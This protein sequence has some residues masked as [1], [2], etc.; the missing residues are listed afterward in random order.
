MY[1]GS[2]IIV[3]AFLRYEERSTIAADGFNEAIQNAI[4]AICTSPNRFRNTYKNFREISL[5]KYPYN[6][7]YYVN[8]GNELVVI[9]SI[10][11]H[12]RNPEG[13]YLKPKK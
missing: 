4:I 1:P 2:T 5:K 13:K 9:I 8:E 3:E 6:L 10:Y 7:I 12:K 11:H